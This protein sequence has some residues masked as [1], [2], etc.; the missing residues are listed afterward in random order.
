MLA[1]G[2]FLFVFAF[3]GLIG[4][5][6]VTFVLH[7]GTKSFTEKLQE[8]FRPAND[9]V[10]LCVQQNQQILQ[11]IEQIRNRL[12]SIEACLGLDT[13]YHGG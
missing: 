6:F 9:G 3:S 8:L 1:I 4:L 11:S 10:D 13:P 5:A 2:G 7:A 12:I